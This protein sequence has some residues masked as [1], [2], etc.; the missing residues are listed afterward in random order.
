MC[1]I[2]LCFVLYSSY[3]LDGKKSGKIDKQKTIGEA[4]R[5]EE[6]IEATILSLKKEGKI[7]EI[8]DSAVNNKGCGNCYGA[9]TSGQCCNTCQDV[10]LAYQRR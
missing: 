5:M 1:K 8:P 9:G 2:F 6:D 4:L 7:T 10:K 3:I